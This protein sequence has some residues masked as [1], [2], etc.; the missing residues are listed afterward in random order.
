[1][2]TINE[3]NFCIEK[4]RELLSEWQSLLIQ[5]ANDGGVNHLSVRAG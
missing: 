5:D 2:L 4:I 3:K 1:M